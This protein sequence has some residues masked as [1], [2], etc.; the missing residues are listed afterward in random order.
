M[1]MAYKLYESAL[2]KVV[3]QRHTLLMQLQGAL[4]ESTGGGSARCE[5][6]GCWVSSF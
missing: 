3:Q 5:L 6:N 4:S 2:K 1:I